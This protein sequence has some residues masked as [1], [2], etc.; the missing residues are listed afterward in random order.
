VRGPQGAQG[1]K[2]P[3][4]PNG[5]QGAQGAA[6][7]TGGAGGIGKTGAQGAQGATGFPGAVCAGPTGFQGEQGRVGDPGGR[8]DIR[9]KKNIQQ[10]T[11]VTQNVLK[12]EVVE[13]EWDEKIGESIYKFFEE[14]GR[15]T[16]LGLIA[17]D[18][19]KYYPEVVDLDERGY[20][21][22]DY[23]KLNAVLIESIKEQQVLIE[24]I[25][26]EINEI[27]KLING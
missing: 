5:G 2:G 23:N 25:D 7:P 21:N 1:E 16:S 27:E 8:S 10:L 19:R 24:K 6:G 15:L 9:L 13:F 20:Y 22:I 18:I 11:G 4:G 3:T 14:R 17:Q 26:I 12:F